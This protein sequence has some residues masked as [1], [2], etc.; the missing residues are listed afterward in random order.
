VQPIP[1]KDNK[2]REEEEKTLPGG[3][4]HGGLITYG[5]LYDRSQLES[6]D[7]ENKVSLHQRSVTS[8]KYSQIKYDNV[9][10]FSYTRI[11]RV[12]LAS[13]ML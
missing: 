2:I 10:P 5:I 7:E 12:A 13:S 4:C 8:T 11:L 9:S 6:R 1:T 3:D